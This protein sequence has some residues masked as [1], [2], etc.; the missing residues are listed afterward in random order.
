MKI[1]LLVAVEPPICPVC[2]SEAVFALTALDAGNKGRLGCEDCKKEFAVEVAGSLTPWTAPTKT[3]KQDLD[4]VNDG[5]HSP[6]IPPVETAK[7]RNI[8]RRKAV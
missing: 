3:A 8:A 7:Q 4:V 1:K 2:K 5:L 6:A